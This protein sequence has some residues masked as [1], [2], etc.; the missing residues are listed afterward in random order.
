MKQTRRKFTAAFKARVSI[1]AIKER[2]TISALSLKYELHPSI[3]GKW[4]QEFIDLSAHV[5]ESKPSVE[6]PN[7]DIEMLYSKIGQLG[8][9]NDFLKKSLKKAGL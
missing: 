6:E 8:M 1:D 3:I 7:Q 9:E 5:F 2:E 4:K